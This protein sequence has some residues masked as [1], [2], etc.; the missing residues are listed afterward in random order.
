MAMLPQLIY[1]FNTVSIKILAG[2]FIDTDKV[3]LKFVWKFK[4]TRIAKTILGKNKVGGSHI[5]TPTLTK[6]K[7]SENNVVLT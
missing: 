4:G 3:I 6:S 5:P 2:F 7:S 1:R